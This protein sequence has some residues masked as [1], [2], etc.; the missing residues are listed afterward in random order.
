LTTNNINGTWELISWQQ[1]EGKA[2]YP[3]GTNPIGYLTYHPE[4]NYVALQVMKV[5]RTK[6]SVPNDNY[7]MMSQTD[8][9]A[10]AEAFY[11]YAGQ[12]TRQDRAITHTIEVAFNPNLV[13]QSQRYQYQ[14]S[15]D[16]L[17][18]SAQDGTWQT[19]WQR[20]KNNQILAQNNLIGIWKLVSM[21]VTFEGFL[22]RLAWMIMDRNTPFWTKFRGE[23]VT[24]LHGQ[25]ASGYIMYNDQGYMSV[26]IMNA[27]RPH[28]TTADE[29]I[30]ASDAEKAQATHTYL[31]YAGP[32]KIQDDQV[33]HQAT[34]S[35]FP[36]FVGADLARVI[37]LEGNQLTL[38]TSMK[39]KSVVVNPIILWE[40][41]A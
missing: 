18:L 26:H 13:G 35:L 5:G 3:F 15:G 36:N 39:V 1:S 41:V 17:T 16:T 19:S 29:V 4:S 31:S 21:Y 20:A 40:R 6:V 25:H 8:E 11:G 9:V 33:I 37:E 10:A 28:L 27:N 2:E 30:W 34:L 7:L 22:A 23:P 32:Y 12:Y 38:S 24:Y 14:L